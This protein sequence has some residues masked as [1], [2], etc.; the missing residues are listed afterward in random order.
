MI[1]AAALLPCLISF[2]GI[3]GLHAN[4]KTKKIGANDVLVVVITLVVVWANYAAGYIA[5]LSK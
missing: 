4:W 5:A 1:P 3:A 2:I